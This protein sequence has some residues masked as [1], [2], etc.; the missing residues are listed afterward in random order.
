MALQFVITGIT[1]M[2]LVL[3][4]FL[5]VPVARNLEDLLPD[6][7]QMT[8]INEDTYCKGNIMTHLDWD[9]VVSSPI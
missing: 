1:Y 3:I 6:H 8:K 5:F 2:T 9:F 4:V 7:N